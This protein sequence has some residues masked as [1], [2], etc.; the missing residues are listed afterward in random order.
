MLTLVPEELEG[1]PRLDGDGLVDG[2]DVLL[3]LTA[4]R[5]RLVGDTVRTTRCEIAM[6]EGQRL[7]PAGAGG[8]GR[9]ERDDF[10]GLEYG[11]RIVQLRARA[12]LVRVFTHV[13]TRGAITLSISREATVLRS[14][15]TW[16][17]A[18][19]QSSLGPYLVVRWE[20]GVAMLA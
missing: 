20:G 13:E 18:R 19:L 5:R 10:D 8:W 7:F 15:G 12:G 1:S 2:D 4:L 3:R 17:P 6:P 14:N 16:L 9:C 11:T